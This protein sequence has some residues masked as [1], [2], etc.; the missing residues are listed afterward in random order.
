MLSRLGLQ[1]VFCGLFLCLSPV[2]PGSAQEIVPRI[3]RPL[4]VL[5]TAERPTTGLFTAIALRVEFQPDTTRFTTGDGTFDTDPYGG[6]VPSVD[7]LPH[8][9]DFFSAHLDGLSHYLDTVSDGQAA[10]RYTLLPEVIQVTGRMQDYTP[11]GPDASADDQLTKLARLVEEAWTVADLQSDAVLPTDIDVD[12]TFFVLL[13]AGVGRD[14]ELVGTTL[15]KTPL[16][17]PSIYFD[18]VTLGRLGVRGASFKGIPV[19]NTAVIPRTETRRGFDFI[20]DEPF[21]VELTTN[22]LLAASF[23]NFLGVPDL[24]N[25]ETGESAIGP[26]GLMDPLGIF[27]YAGLIPPEPGAWTKVFLGWVEPLEVRSGFPVHATLRAASTNTSE[28]V[29]VWISESEYFLVENRHR[30][31]GSDGLVMRVWDRGIVSEQRVPNGDPEFNSVNIDGFSGGVVTRVDEYDWSLPGGLDEEDNPLVGGALIWHVDERRIRETIGTNALN[32]DP[33]WRGVDLEEADSGQDLGNPSPGVFGPAL[34]Q[35]SPFDFFYEGNPVTVIT[36]SGSEIR[37]YENRFGDDTYPDSRSN[38]GGPS[39]IEIADFSVPGPEMTL[40]IRRVAGGTAVPVDDASFNLSD[41]IGRLR[42]ESDAGMTWCTDAGDP[43][44]AVPVVD[45]EGARSVA[46]ADDL[47]FVA[48][49]DGFDFTGAQL[50]CSGDWLLAVASEAD[51]YVLVR[52][53]PRS[54]VTESTPLGVS[55]FDFS[56]ATQILVDGAR[57]HVAFAS[58]SAGRLVS[59][60]VSGE[61]V[62]VLDLPSRPRSLALAG[63]SR[64]A[65]GLEQSVRLIDAEGTTAAEWILEGGGVEEAYGLAF[66]SDADGQL[67]VLAGRH[68]VVL[69]LADGTVVPAGAPEPAGPRRWPVLEDVDGDGRLDVVVAHEDGLTAYTRGGAIAGGFPIDLGETLLGQVLTGR[70]ATDS[71]G[72]RLL[73]TGE[74]GYVYAIDLDRRGRPPDGFPLAAAAGT[75]PAWSGNRLYTVSGGGDFRVWELSG[76]GVPRW[77]ELFGDSS[78]R[79]FAESD[80]DPGGPEGSGLLVASETYNWP[81]PVS[82]GRTHFRVA[83]TEDASLGI[84]IVDMAGARIDHLGAQL[85]RAGAPFELLWETDAQSGVYFANV[86]A[87]AASGRVESRLITFA[88][89]R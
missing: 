13:H 20:T 35:G 21:L 58:E 6:L 5:S 50:A 33:S 49:A 34:D 18:E 12:R 78:N 36:G 37:L 28:V 7:P 79:S 65:V 43:F 72:L 10:L 26:F 53:D 77:K 15:D 41:E 44:Y 55:A 64:L 11:I 60:D 3:V 71:S 32:S 30:D 17:L 4:S 56:P 42:V 63:E 89:V 54:A 67:G 52:I 86:T 87:T 51:S 38:G 88:I 85:V 31:T 57:V 83:T 25:T 70:D 73:A 81:N 22:G 23:F 39:F 66:G 29:R 24:F 16:D 76:F 1:G 62:S 46:F 69:L 61:T 27:A 14:I 84:T 19:T 9:A 75:T 47:G 40:V 45:E 8:G 59:V 82:E 48:R 74:S 68:G 2:R 80:T